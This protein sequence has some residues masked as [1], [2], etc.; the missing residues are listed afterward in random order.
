[1]PTVREHLASKISSLPRHATAN[2]LRLLTSCCTWSYRGKAD[3]PW[4]S[5][6]PTEIKKTF[7]QSANSHIHQDL[8]PPSPK[9]P[10]IWCCVLNY[11]RAESPG[12]SRNPAEV[13]R[14]FSRQNHRQNMP[15]ACVPPLACLRRGAGDH[16]TPCCPLFSLEWAGWGWGYAGPDAGFWLWSHPRQ[17]LQH[18]SIFNPLAV[19]RCALGA[20]RTY[21]VGAL[22]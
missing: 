16:P 9:R 21:T 22:I 3:R 5:R 10:V 19:D 18:P 15:S 4:L 7:S 14:T 11:R 8:W 2:P 17:G 13:E 1:M 6:K 20:L 12:F